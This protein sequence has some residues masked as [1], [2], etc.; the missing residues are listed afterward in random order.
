M[1]TR[2][3]KGIGQQTDW[4]LCAGFS[5]NTYGFQA[6]SNQQ[7]IQ[8]GPRSLRLRERG[9]IHLVFQFGAKPIELAGV[10]RSFNRVQTLVLG[11]SVPRVFRSIS[12]GI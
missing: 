9:F 7:I 1:S 6:H 10:E 12:S 4:A 3:L 5:K 2:F 11:A 8:S